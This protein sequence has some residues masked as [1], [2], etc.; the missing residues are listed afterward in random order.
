[1]AGVSGDHLCQA[2]LIKSTLF[3]TLPSGT[4]VKVGAYDSINQ[5]W[6]YRNVQTNGTDAG[7][8]I[9]S[10]ATCT[11]VTPTTCETTCE[12]IEVTVLSNDTEYGQNPPTIPTATIHYIGCDGPQTYSSQAGSSFNIC[13]CV[14]QNNIIAPNGATFTTSSLGPCPT[15]TTTA[16]PTTTTTSTST[17]TS[18]TTTTTEPCACTSYTISNIGPG[19]DTIDYTDCDTGISSTIRPGDIGVGAWTDVQS[20]TICSQTQPTFGFLATVT[21]NGPCCGAPQQITYVLNPTTTTT[22]VAPTTTT[23]TVAP[24]TTTTTLPEPGPEG[25]CTVTITDEDLSASEFGTVILEIIDGEGMS[26]SIAY[27]NSGT[28]SVCIGTL[29]AFYIYDGVGGDG[30]PVNTSTVIASG[31]PCTTAEDCSSNP[32]QTTTTTSNSV[33]ITLFARQENIPSDLDFHYST[34]G[35]ITWNITGNPFTEAG[36]CTQVVTLS[37]PQGSDLVVRIGSSTDVNVSYPSVRDTTICPNF[38]PGN[39]ICEWPISTIVSRSFYFT[40]DVQ[41]SNPCQ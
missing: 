28:Y 16:A 21:P 41:N 33:N 24:T 38:D 6:K 29:N 11:C 20:I 12:Y 26:Q 31:V 15:T 2:V 14:T 25:C 35:G 19:D 18:S 36:E 34:N 7:Q 40:V 22:T 17:T 3:A 10:C 39:A 5:I 32:E 30:L 37:L 23:T 13:V 8:F 9:S 1:M 4:I 27:Q